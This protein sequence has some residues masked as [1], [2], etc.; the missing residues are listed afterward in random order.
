M[1]LKTK[2][3][4]QTLAASLALALILV[5]IFLFSLVEIR[6]SALNISAELGDNFADLSVDAMEGQFVYNIA[7]TARDMAF[8][9]DEKLA[10]IE[11]LTEVK[12]YTA[13]AIYTSIMQY[14]LATGGGAAEAIDE[15]G[16]RHIAEIL[17]QSAATDLGVSGSII[18]GESGSVFQIEQGEEGAAGFP[19]VYFDPR[20]SDWYKVKRSVFW[21]PVY[22][23]EHSGAP[24]LSGLAPFFERSTGEDVF[25]GLVRSTLSIDDFSEIFDIDWEGDEGY[26]FLLDA[27]GVNFFSRGRAFF[28]PGG[29][30]LLDGKNF[31]QSADFYLRGLGASMV[32]GGFG[33][34]EMFIG[35]SPAVAAYSPIP[36]LG[37]SLGIVIPVLDFTAPVTLIEQ[38]I[39]GLTAQAAENIDRR[40]FLLAWIALP[41]LLIS[42]LAIA[43]FF[44]RFTSTIADPIHALNAGVRDVR[45][46]NFDRVVSVETGDELEDLASSFNIMT[47]RLREQ[48]S[49]ISID[50]IEKE[51]ISGELDVAARIQTSM[52]PRKFTPFAGKKNDFDLFAAVYPAKEVGGDF[53]DFFY[54]DEDHFA[55]LIADVSGQGVPAAIFMAIAKTLI[56]NNLKNAAEPNISMQN[57]N[58]QLCKINSE[59]M[60][61]TVWLGV[62]E[63]STGRLKFINAGHNP[64][65]IKRGSSCFELLQTPPDTVLAAL[66]G[67]AYQCREVTL[68]DGDAI[69]L[70]TDGITEAID[71]QGN[72]FGINRLLAFMNANANLPPKEL[73]PAVRAGIEHF[74]C[75]AA[76]FDD[77]TMLALR[78]DREKAVR[79]LR[80]TAR[81]G[82]LA[83]LI[84][85]IGQDLE[86]ILCPEKIRRQIELAAEEIFINI[87]RYAYQD[88]YGEVQVGCCVQ[89]DEGKV[90]V[91]ITF[92]DWGEP[93]NPLEVEGPDLNNQLEERKIGGLGILMVKHIMDIIDYEYDDGVNHLIMK[94]SWKA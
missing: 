36:T 9:L 20:E 5:A 47:D 57:I 48:V 19:A 12:A 46:G 4:T 75:G 21:S 51:R 89:R 22:F 50:T 84:H 34:V 76:Q 7:Q 93:F 92:A 61:V 86:S 39:K 30:R 6:N 49:K 15:S 42:L 59:T 94:K 79:T 44:I 13:G 64:P 78:Y 27:D 33:I 18:A 38:R 14:H 81:P 52:L 23:D 71:S 73:L 70:Y 54:I 66:D 35:G 16:L 25:K 58:Q 69:F 41:V 83:A 40:I 68:Q 63:L 60:F 82:D 90:S 26:I 56:K 2:I 1:N 87:G 11:Y 91:S 62:L 55:M 77:I 43:L 8:T 72:F 67:T 28:F 85:F 37:W 80:L 88:F 24:F 3:L 45:S 32:E 10:R 53:Y 65:L 74:S 29:C 17:S 31:L